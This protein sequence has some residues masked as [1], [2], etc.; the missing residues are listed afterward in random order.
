M[1]TAADII[2]KVSRWCVLFI[3]YINYYL[4]SELLQMK[5]RIFARGAKPKIVELAINVEPE[6][7]ES[8]RQGAPETENSRTVKFTGWSVKQPKMAELSNCCRQ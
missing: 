2:Y 6:N 5:S 4:V 1:L 7:P 3:H 8:Q